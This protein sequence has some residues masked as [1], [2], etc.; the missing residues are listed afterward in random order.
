MKFV[1]SL[2]TVYSDN[3][4]E[5]DIRRHALKAHITILCHTKSMRGLAILRFY[6]SVAICMYVLLESFMEQSN[7]YA[8][9]SRRLK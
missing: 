8:S 1:F 3:K 2:V 5:G 6:Q 7:A 4:M 9:Y